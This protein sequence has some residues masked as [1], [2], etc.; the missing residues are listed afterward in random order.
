MNPTEKFFLMYGI[1]IIL[2]IPLIMFYNKKFK[3][4]RTPLKIALLSYVA[5]IAFFF[6]TLDN[7]FDNDEDDEDFFAGL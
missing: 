5:V 7:L 6:A 1:G 4:D 2:A 3:H